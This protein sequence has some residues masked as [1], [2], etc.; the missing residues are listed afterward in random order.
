MFSP[1]NPFRSSQPQQNF[2]DH[3]TY[4]PPGMKRA[5][6][7]YEHGSQN[8]GTQQPVTEPV[9]GPQVIAPGAQ[10]P[11]GQ[12][13]AAATSPQTVNP[14][15]PQPQSPDQAYDFINN[16]IKPPKEP[17]L[18]KI[19]GGSLVLRIVLAVGILIFFIIAISVFKSISNRSTAATAAALISV[20]QDQQELLHIVGE[21]AQQSGLASNHQNFAATLKLSVASSQSQLISYILAG[22][23]KLTTQQLNLKISSSVDSQLSNAITD[24]TFDQTFQQVMQ[25][26]LNSYGK[27]LQKAYAQDK[28]PKGRAIL[29]DSYDQA[30]LLYTQLSSAQSS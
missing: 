17:L 19:T 7:Q 23:Q 9:Q 18:S 20:V 22:H 1:K 11:Q 10:Q 16:P 3:E 15:Q 2:Q 12:P 5:M 27:D 24:N 4:L 6:D 25:S 26:Q 13:P 14:M 29:K 30:Q 8:Q 21:S 28:G